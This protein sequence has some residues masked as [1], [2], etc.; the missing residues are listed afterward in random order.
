ME[1]RALRAA[2]R[3]SRLV[4]ITLKGTAAA[5]LFGLRLGSGGQPAPC[6]SMRLWTL[7]PR[8]LD[9]KG[10]VAAWREALLAQKVLSGTTRGYR[11]HPQLVRFRAAADPAGAIATFLHELATE[12]ARRGYRFDT[13]KIAAVRAAGKIRET[14]GQLDFEWSHLIRKLEVRAPELARRWREVVSPEPH[15]LFRVTNGEVREWEKRDATSN[16]TQRLRAKVRQTRSGGGVS[17]RR[18]KMG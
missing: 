5:G 9:S 16:S 15:P 12:A 8:Y 10:L 18:A 11:N 3:C 1:R 7:H 14:R 17:V 13:T 2:M 4:P 6:C